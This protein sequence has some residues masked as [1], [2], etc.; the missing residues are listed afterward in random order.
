V[1]TLIAAGGQA[2]TAKGM[3]VAS[4]FRP[5]FARDRLNQQLFEGDPS[6]AQRLALH[7]VCEGIVVGVLGIT[8]ARSSDAEGMYTARASLRVRLI[9]ASSGSVA[10]EFVLSSLGAGFSE[11]AARMQATERLVSPL[12]N[13]LAQGPP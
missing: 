13:R 1:P 2:L 4:V 9:T 6:L 5:A 12:K 3:T 11:D 10:E 8:I 7:D